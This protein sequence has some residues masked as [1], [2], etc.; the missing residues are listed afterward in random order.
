MIF[1]VKVNTA[2]NLG[3]L[4]LIRIFKYRTE[5]KTGLN[6]VQKLSVQQMPSGNFFSK[7]KTQDLGI[8]PVHQ[9]SAFGYLSYPINRFPNWF[10]SPLTKVKF[11]RI[12]LPWYKIPDFIQI[13][14]VLKG[15]W[16]PS[17]LD[18]DLVFE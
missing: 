15:I 6:P 7:A 17:R 9:L 8:E 1:L 13:V 4:N 16:E 11:Q 10:Y 18:W 5:V 2:L 3:F 14:A 12:I